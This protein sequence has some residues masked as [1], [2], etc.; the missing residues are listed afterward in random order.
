MPERLI[1]KK[2]NNP[3]HGHL[4]T[5]LSRDAQIPGS[6]SPWL[7]NFVRWRLKFVDPQYRTSFMSP[8]WRLVLLIG[9][10]FIG[11]FVTLVLVYLPLFVF[12]LVKSVTS[13]KMSSSVSG[14]P[15]H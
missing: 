1:L 14:T 3:E 9:Y 12:I 15:Q 11:E 7:R 13:R 8:F 4:N 10:L 5:Y 6:R 2:G